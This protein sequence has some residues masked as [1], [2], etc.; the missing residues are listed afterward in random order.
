MKLYLT[1]V[2]KGSMDKIDFQGKTKVAF[3]PTAAD[4]YIDKFF[5][6]EDREALKLKGLEVTDYDIKDK[7]E[8]EVLANLQAFEIIFVAGG[9]SYYL[10]DKMNQCNFKDILK[11][12]SDNKIYVGSSAGSVVTA[13]NT[14]YV[15]LLDDPSKTP[16]LSS[17]DA[18]GLVDFY[19]LPHYGREKYKE[20]CKKIL[21]T[22][23]SLN[24]IPLKDEELIVVTG[25]EYKKL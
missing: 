5:I 15:E 22:Y 16:N 24:I 10:L 25:T 20:R 14:A 11:K 18:L 3:I 17:Y 4:P 7:S 23:K 2:A 12:L 21:E 6:E 19:I 1:S 8:E 9:N 13:P